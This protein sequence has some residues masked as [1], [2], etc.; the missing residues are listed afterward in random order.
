MLS[1]V[2]DSTCAKADPEG[3][4]A[5][6]SVNVMSQNHVMAAMLAKW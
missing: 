4:E 5:D 1:S 6:G 2:M 3:R